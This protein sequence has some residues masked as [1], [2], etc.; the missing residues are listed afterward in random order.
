MD[1]KFPRFFYSCMEIGYIAA[2]A[3]TNV[4]HLI[5]LGLHCYMLVSHSEVHKSS[6]CDTWFTV[7]LI[8]FISCGIYA[9]IYTSCIYMSLI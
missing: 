9:L 4:F 8:I 7:L 5:V 6:S 3:D 2:M 1:F